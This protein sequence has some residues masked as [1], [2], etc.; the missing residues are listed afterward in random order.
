MARNVIALRRE[1]G[2]FVRSL[3]AVILRVALG[4]VFLFSGLSKLEL[5]KEGKYPEAITSQYPAKIAFP[6][7]VKLFTDVLPYAEAGLGA[8]LIAG[9]WTPIS[10][11]LAGVLLLVLFFGHIHKQNAAMY[12]AMM[13]YI[14]ADAAVLWLSPVTSNYLSLDGILFGFFWRPRS[15]G[16]F[17]REEPEAATGARRA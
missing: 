12:P 15:E 17:R 16:Q 10:S 13:T 2:A 8:A 9:F 11:F 3:T 1:P 7:D 6:G 5:K 4:M 14:L